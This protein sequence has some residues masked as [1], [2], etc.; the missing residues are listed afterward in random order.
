MTPPDAPTARVAVP[1]PT[2]ATNKVVV[3]PATTPPPLPADQPTN[4]VSRVNHA[5]EEKTGFPPTFPEVGARFLGFRLVEELG[6]GAFGR[7][8]LAYQGDLAGRPVALKVAPDIFGES[9]TLAQLQHTNIVPIY[10]LHQAGPYQAV[11]MPF[12]GRTTLSQVLAAVSGR[13][14][15][16]HSGR[17]L[18]ST[19]NRRSSETS[20]PSGWRS[21][22]APAA[23]VPAPAPA[24]AG[25]AHSPDG[26]ARLEGL[27][28]VEAP[29]G[30]PT[31]TPA[32]SSTAT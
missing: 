5:A 30:W 27:S 28:Y 24:P 25:A 29:T 1:L 8:Y 19:L 7:V 16:P 23:P 21:N 12:F 17:E 31:P 2:D 11:C 4:R 32:A 14:T 22:P 6:R 9:Q 10:S 26:W 20:P 18:V 13:G 3:H 15:L